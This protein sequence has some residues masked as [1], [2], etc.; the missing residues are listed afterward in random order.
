M[1]IYKQSKKSRKSI[2]NRGR[3][4]ISKPIQCLYEDDCSVV[5]Y[6]PSGLLVIPTP[7]NETN[8]LVDIVN[9]QYVK[10][11]NKIVRLYP[12]HRLDRE[13]SGA[14]LFAKGKANQK[15]LMNLFAQK[16]INKKY[17]AF[18]QGR[19]KKN[20][21]VFKGVVRDIDQ[22]K[23]VQFSSGKEAET[24]YCVTAQKKEYAIVEVVPVTGR[25]NQIRI[26]F[27]KA[28]HPIV[29]DRKYAFARDYELK[30]RRTALHA[31]CLQWESL[32]DNLKIKV[33]APLPNDMASFLDKH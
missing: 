27:S 19:M 9:E 6:K 31:A 16:Q 12:A 29:G 5:F 30:F 17:I 28:G 4:A 11:L 25:T 2:S 1:V 23:Y 8:T 10:A 7:K 13:T 26:H 32:E 33:E 3:S 14:I 21:G 22:R 24:H 15:K 20:K 18:V